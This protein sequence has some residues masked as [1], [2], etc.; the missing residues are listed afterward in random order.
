MLTQKFWRLEKQRRMFLSEE[1]DETFLT[2]QI[3]IKLD[4]LVTSSEGE[5]VASVE[6]LLELTLCRLEWSILNEGK[7]S[8]YAKRVSK[9]VIGQTPVRLT[10]QVEGILRQ[11]VPVAFKHAPKAVTKSTH[12]DCY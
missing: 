1:L 4:E 9:M 10:Q 5:G 6:A 11:V 2:S 3:L 7:V 8:K 12:F